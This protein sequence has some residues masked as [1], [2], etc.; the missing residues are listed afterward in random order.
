MLLNRWLINLGILNGSAVTTPT[1]IVGATA[2]LQKTEVKTVSSSA[3]LVLRTALST[4]G[5]AVLK[6]TVTLAVGTSVVCQ[7]ADP[8]EVVFGSLLPALN[9]RLTDLFIPYET[10]LGGLENRLTVSEQLILGGAVVPYIEPQTDAILKITVKDTAGV[11]VTDAVATATVVYSPAG[12]SVAS[13]VTMPHQGA[14]VYHLSISR[15][16]SDNSGKAIEGEFVAEV[17]VT[18]GGV[19]RRRRFRYP[20]KFDDED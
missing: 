15:A 11:V 19:E 2:V 13:N 18:R 20:V 14:G 3:Q 8:V 6:K 10:S 17:K 5:S 7:G 16:W 1:R 4:T 12:V 9:V